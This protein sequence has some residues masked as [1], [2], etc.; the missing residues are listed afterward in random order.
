MQSFCIQCCY[1]VV[2]QYPFYLAR[3]RR[4]LEIGARDDLFF[5]HLRSVN[6]IL[7]SSEQIKG[8]ST[9]KHA[10][11][12]WAIG[13]GSSYTCLPFLSS[14]SPSFVPPSNSPF[15]DSP[16]SFKTGLKSMKTFLESPDHQGSWEIS[17]EIST[18]S[19]VILE[20]SLLVD[21]PDSSV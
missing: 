9:H 5:L 4:N 1:L 18:A 6:W 14:P 2:S 8:C 11:E 13:I 15:R 7:L 19:T 17:V 12:Y 16:V 3:L 10:F 20:A 21:D